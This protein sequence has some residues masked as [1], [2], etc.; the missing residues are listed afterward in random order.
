MAVHHPR[1]GVL[2]F[3]PPRTPPGRRLGHAL[4][5]VPIQHRRVPLR[6]HVPGLEPGLVRRRVV[7][8]VPTAEIPVVAAVGVEGV[9]VPAARVAVVVEPDD[10]E[11]LAELGREGER[12]RVPAVVGQGGVVI[13]DSGCAVFVD[14]DQVGRGDARGLPDV[15]VLFPLQR[16]VEQGLHGDGHGA[17]DGGEGREGVRSGVEGRQGRFYPVVDLLGEGE[18]LGCGERYCCG[19]WGGAGHVVRENGIAGHIC[20]LV[21]ILVLDPIRAFLVCLELGEGLGLK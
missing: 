2:H 11:H 12:R 8:P 19:C 14:V 21:A 18:R 4:H 6:R 5:R 3:D 7:R 17:R 13:G 20:G 10:V 15:A 1:A 9:D 16:A